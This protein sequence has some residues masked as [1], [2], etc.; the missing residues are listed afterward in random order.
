MKLRLFKK[1]FKGKPTC[2]Y[3]IYN[4]GYNC[5]RYP[6][7]IA[8]KTIDFQNTDSI[9]TEFPFV[10]KYTDWCGEFKAR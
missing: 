2:Y 9:I 6:P 4:V 1:K 7:Q 3:C 8:A 5:H 10:N